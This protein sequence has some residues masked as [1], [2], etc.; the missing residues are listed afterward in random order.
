MYAYVKHNVIRAQNAG[1]SIAVNVRL[2]HLPKSW[3]GSLH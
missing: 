1:V 2:Q 3:S